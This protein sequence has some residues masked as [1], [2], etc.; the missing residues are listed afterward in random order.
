M[1][2]VADENISERLVRILDLYDKENEVRHLKAYADQGTPDI[3]LLKEAAAFRPRP[4]ILSMAAKITK[5]DTEIFQLRERGLHF[6]LLQ[7]V[8]MAQGWENMVWQ[9]LRIWPRIV[10]DT[11]RLRVPSILEVD[12]RK[13]TLRKQLV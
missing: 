7:R 8:W 10:E 11:A 4:V 2:F 12:Q 5:R 6:V 9:L 3:E 13:V 1:R